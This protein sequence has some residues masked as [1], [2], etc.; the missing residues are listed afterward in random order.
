MIECCLATE[1]LTKAVEI[2]AE[3]M[4][5]NRI[6]ITDSNFFGE[7]QR[8]HSSHHNLFEACGF[9]QQ[10][11]ADDSMTTREHNASTPCYGRVAGL[12]RSQR[13]FL[14]MQEGQSSDEIE[15]MAVTHDSAGT[16]TTPVASIHEQREDDD[17]DVDTSTTSSYER[18][19][20]VSAVETAK[21]PTKLSKFD[22][23]VIVS[24]F[25]ERKRDRTTCCSSTCYL[26]LR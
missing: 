11:T 15:I 3:D 14:L 7:L 26:K 20:N 25:M 12:R 9:Y 23:G 1:S 10:F 5:R 18:N 13:A 8:L 21:I 6:L 24:Y 2:C 19:E 17:A 22:E 4:F 16:D